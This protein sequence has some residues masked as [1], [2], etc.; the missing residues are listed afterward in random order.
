MFENQKK[1]L[2]GKYERLKKISDYKKAFNEISKELKNHVGFDIILHR[3]VHG[4]NMKSPTRI[5]KKVEKK[6]QSYSKF[7]PL[8]NPNQLQI[9][10]LAKKFHK[11]QYAIFDTSFFQKLPEV[12]KL[13]PIPLAITK[14]DHLRKYGFHG[15]SH[16]S[17]SKGLK[18]KTIT[19]HL[20]RG[21]SM[22]AIK[23]GNPV[24]T[25]MGLTPME[26]LMMGTRSGSVDPGLI[27]HL[28]KKGYDTN[29]IL[30]LQSGLKGIS[31]LDDFR[32]ILKTMKKN[33]TSKL[34]YDMFLFHIIEYIG[35][36]AAALDGLNNLVFTGTIGVEVPKLREDICKHLDFLGIKLDKTKNKQKKEVISAKNSKVKILV[37]TP[38]EDTLMVRLVKK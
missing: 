21:A 29:K 24:D 37:R 7:A 5:T 17:V 31:G 25:S 10:K 18:G 6:I 36:Y 27:I 32:E 30:N 22:T 9:I 34:A 26:G 15:I 14:K 1:V 3:V 8:H 28:N 2:E 11:P 16:A 4:G 13:Y 12:A 20:G 19:V 23:N 33:K 38:E 35:S